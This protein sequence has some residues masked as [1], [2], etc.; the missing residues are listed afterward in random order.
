MQGWCTNKWSKV[1]TS[2]FCSQG[3]LKIEHLL[4]LFQAK[5]TRL[6]LTTTM[7]AKKSWWKT[8]SIFCT[9]TTTWW[10]LHLDIILVTLLGPKW[11]TA[12][13]RLLTHLGKGLRMQRCVQWKII[14]DLDKKSA[15]EDFPCGKS[16]SIHEFFFCLSLILYWRIGPHS[17]IPCV[18]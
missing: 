7:T 13:H 2:Y 9:P 12:K 11:S 17:P 8:Q 15:L 1:K 3:C 4:I 6:W 18:S 5:R 10:K 14:G 16:E